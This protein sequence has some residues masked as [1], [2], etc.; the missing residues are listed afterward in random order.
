MNKKLIKRTL[1]ILSSKVIL[2]LLIISMNP[3]S[4]SQNISRIK[5]STFYYKNA[6]KGSFV[7]IPVAVIR[8]GFSIG[9][10]RYISKQS[11]IE[12]GGYYL[13]TADDMGLKYQTICI[14][15]AYKYFVF[16]Q[17]K[18]I[19]SI[20][21]SVYLSYLNETT[22][23]P[24]S[25]DNFRSSLYYYGIGGSIGKKIYLSK[26]KDWF[27]DIG[28]GVSYNIY[29]D[30]PLFSGNDWSNKMLPRPIIQIGRKF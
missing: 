25:E 30:K 17:N 4:F 6:I 22:D 9:Y 26:R 24:E 18:E 28:L 19:E 23:Y 20:W 3:N 16:L 27:I 15:P 7:I 13:F 10:E 5:D 2:F 11:V 1:R 14:M 12:L 8:V 29:D 21:L